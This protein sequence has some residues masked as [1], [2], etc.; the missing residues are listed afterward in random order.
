MEKSK[1][2]QSRQRRLLGKA[3]M[4]T[5]SSDPYRPPHG[6]F[7]TGLGLGTPPYQG[8]RSPHGMCS[9]YRPVQEYHSVFQINVNSF[10]LL[11][12]VPTR[13]PGQPHCYIC[14]LKGGDWVLY[15]GAQD[16][17][18][19]AKCPTLDEPTGSRERSRPTPSVELVWLRVHRH[20]NIRGSAALCW[21]SHS[22]TKR[23]RIDAFTSAP[24]DKQQ[25]SVCSTE[26]DA[27]VNEQRKEKQGRESVTPKIGVLKG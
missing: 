26:I 6:C 18:I 12:H 8:M 24:G 7:R 16:G 2:K 20:S 5:Q 3:V 4:R 9:A 21:L 17:C 14:S 19:E 10:V 27:E 22:D 11:K 1:L 25:M 13:A 23:R 15:S